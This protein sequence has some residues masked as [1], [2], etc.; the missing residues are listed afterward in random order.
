MDRR[1]S[2]VDEISLD[3]LLAR[4]NSAGRSLRVTVEA[5]DDD[6][7]RV[8]VTPFPAG[9]GCR[10][11][12]SLTIPKAQIRRLAD[13]SEVHMCC[14][15]QLVVVEIEFSEPVLTDVFEQ[16]SSRAAP[17][18]DPFAPPVDHP[19]GNRWAGPPPVARY[20]GNFEPRFPGSARIRGDLGTPGFGGPGGGSLPDL[21]CS[22]HYAECVQYG[23]DPRDSR[24]KC[25]CA[26]A[27]SSCRGWGPFRCDMYPP[28]PPAW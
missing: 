28:F 3:D 21:S 18:L 26:S 9:A 20:I 8:K 22:I 24:C 27:Y 11:P 15:K 12:Q 25:E 4:Q 17:A 1:T 23:C 19:G 13:T 2:T 14:G 6:P 5:V 16:L 10:C 7:E